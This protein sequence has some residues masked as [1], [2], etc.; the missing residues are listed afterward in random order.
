MVVMHA[1]PLPVDAVRDF[2]DWVGLWAGL[3]TGVVGI[4]LALLAQRT[5]NKARAEGEAAEIRAVERA[6]RDRR[7]VFELEIL[8]DLAEAVGGPLGAKLAQRPA[9]FIDIARLAML[10]ADEL[11]TMRSLPTMDFEQRLRLAKGAP[12]EVLNSIRSDFERTGR[13]YTYPEYMRPFRAALLQEIK[14]AIE[15]RAGGQSHGAM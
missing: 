5:A 4:I 3:G 12:P 8:R 13:L 15:R 6:A 9:E 11:L 1:D 2:W 10:P 14:E 7:A